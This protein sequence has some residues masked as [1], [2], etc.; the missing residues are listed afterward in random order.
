MALN[1][2]LYLF[3][4][5]ASGAVGS[6]EDVVISPFMLYFWSPVTL[7]HYFLR[8][9]KSVF[10]KCNVFRA[11]YQLKAGFQGWGDTEQLFPISP[12]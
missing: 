10:L 1:R 8:G 4:L 5:R 2:R 7:T 6:D 3:E 11:W 12:E 9:G